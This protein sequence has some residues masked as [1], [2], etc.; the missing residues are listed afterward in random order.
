MEVSV[1]PNGS[2]KGMCQYSKF[3]T[4]QHKPVEGLYGP[5]S[6]GH[7]QLPVGAAQKSQETLYL[8]SEI[9][10]QE[11]LKLKSK[12]NGCDILSLIDFSF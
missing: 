5:P 3:C 12:C 2:F 4:Y 8:K 9:F 1:N 11:L 10:K 7:K 6:A